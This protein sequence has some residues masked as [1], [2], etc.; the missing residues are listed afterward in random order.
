MKERIVSSLVFLLV[1]I[2]GFILGNQYYAILLG[3]CA[4]LGVRE[5]ILVKQNNNNLI[6]VKILNYI[7]VLLLTFNNV[8]FIIDDMVVI[9]YLIL[10]NLFSVLVYQNK[11]NLTASL[12]IIGITYILGLAF[13][14]IL[15][16]R[17]SNWYLCLFIFIIAFS[18]DI[19]DYVTGCLIGKHQLKNYPK[20][21][22]E[23]IIIGII[24]SCVIG[25]VY[26]Y[27]VIGSISVIG[28]ILLCL[29]LSIMSVVGD[30]IFENIKRYHKLEFYYELL[31]GMKGILDRFDSILFVALGLFLFL[32]VF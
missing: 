3:C 30:L 7:G 27:N 5:F 15:G 16:L 2:I 26:Y 18:N 1:L 25:Y 6:L 29:F 28:C 10:S 14:I 9:L 11:Y 23:S 19:Y 24:M 32:S 13:N 8:Y 21:S 12:N 17:I 22:Y 31:P 4:V 20:K